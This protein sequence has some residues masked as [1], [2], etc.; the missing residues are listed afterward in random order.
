LKD[1]EGDP[2]A[3]IGLEDSESPIGARQHIPRLSIVHSASPNR[4]MLVELLRSAELLRKSN[5]I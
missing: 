1:A 5:D 3:Q 4:S 2:P